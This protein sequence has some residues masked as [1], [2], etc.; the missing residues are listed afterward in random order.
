[1]NIFGLI[2]VTLLIFSFNSYFIGRLIKYY[3]RYLNNAICFALGSISLFAIIQLGLFLITLIS[4]ISYKFIGFYLLAIQLILIVIY[5]I[6]WRFS[7][8]KIDFNWKTIIYLVCIGLIILLV[9]LMFINYQNVTDQNNVN[10]NDQFFLFSSGSEQTSIFTKISWLFLNLF[11]VTNLTQNSQYIFLL[12]YSIFIATSVYG[13]YCYNKEHHLKNWKFLL[14]LVGYTLLIGILSLS[15]QPNLANGYGW[16]L[17]ILLI[18][19]YLHEYNYYNGYD[20]KCSYLI[21]SMLIGLFLLNPQAIL[22]IITLGLYIIYDNFKKQI[23]F[24]WSYNFAILCTIFFCLG[25]FIYY[26]L[27]LIGYIISCLIL[28]INIVWKNLKFFTKRNDKK[29]KLFFYSYPVNK[30]L[31]FGPIIFLPVA[32]ITIIIVKQPFTFDSLIINQFMNK[33]LIN[34][35]IQYWIINIFY[36]V[37]I[38]LPLVLTII[39]YIAIWAKKRLLD[40]ELNTLNNFNYLFTINPITSEFWPF[41]FN[42]NLKTVEASSN[43]VCL[44]YL[45]ACEP[46]KISQ[47]NKSVIILFTSVVTTMFIGL[48]I[49]NFIG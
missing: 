28:L 19:L 30:I 25:L 46:E 43:V 7:L 6:N 11:H 49:F 4:S 37:F 8:M 48:T 15:W 1:M 34:G 13:V 22:I 47:K 17:P 2:I 42:G 41:V 9:S 36:W 31:L 10:W 32:L 5:A 38:S 20:I 33:Q 44:Y 14:P 16:I 35:S 18:I 24:V 23:P 39:H 21:N 3:N 27:S 29:K 12:P 40:N 45:K 26:Y